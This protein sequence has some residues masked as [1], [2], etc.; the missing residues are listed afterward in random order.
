MRSQKSGRDSLE[1]RVVEGGRAKKCRE[2]EADETN[3]ELL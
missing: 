2:A 3:A 1:S